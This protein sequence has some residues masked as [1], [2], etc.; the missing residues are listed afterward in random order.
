MGVKGFVS[1]KRVSNRVRAAGLAVGIGLCF[2]L[3]ECKSKLE[4]SSTVRLVAQPYDGDQF[5][6]IDRRVFS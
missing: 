3:V 1:E 5:S 6:V 2:G 4:R